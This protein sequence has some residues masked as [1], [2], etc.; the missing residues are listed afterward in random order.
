MVYPQEVFLCI[1]LVNR[2]Y[3]LKI[4]WRNAQMEEKK[5]SVIKPTLCL[6][7]KNFSNHEVGKNA[8]ALAYYLLFTIFP[9]MIFFSNLLGLLDINI[10]FASEQINRFMPR[11]VVILL[12]SYFDYVSNSSSYKLL[13]F[14]LV[15]SIWF[16]MRAAS[17]IMDSVRVAYHLE[18]PENS[19][20]YI[21]KQ[22]LYTVVLLFAI[23]AC[24][25]LT[26]IGKKF[27]MFIW[28]ITPDETM[29]LVELFASIWQYFRF[30]PIGLLMLVPLGSLYSLSLDE[31]QKQ[32]AMIPGILVAMFVWMVASIAFSFY[33]ENIASYSIIY[34]TLGAMIILLMWL[35]LTAL[36]IIM[37]VEFN[38]AL[39]EVRGEEF[40]IRTE[41]EKLDLKERAKKI[42]TD[43]PAIFL[44]LKEKDTP[45]I[46]K[47]F[48]GITIVYALS[49]IDLVP[50]FIPGL[51]YLDDVIILPV[52]IALT[53]K[54]IPKDVLERSR[55]Q[56]EGMWQD[57]KPKKW[58]YAIPIL[59]IWFFVFYLIYCVVK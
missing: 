2:V 6:V 22:L 38:A 14:S 55:E 10:S 4:G 33:V 59:V 9:L 31:K 51:G 32:G 8:A 39:Q 21:M 11:D 17:G 46:A 52:L 30:L 49:P 36:S 25:I 58:Y 5:K 19:I 12:E 50:D 40:Q 37:G 44:A 29:W 13:W 48:A 20:K 45:L 24:L 28:S 53:I 18:K 23:V 54:Y 26:I 47:I 27:M 34:G 16:P 57:G 7:A 1:Y 56:S 35:Y 3:I 42:K 41:I 43:V 15:F